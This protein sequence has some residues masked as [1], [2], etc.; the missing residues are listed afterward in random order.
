MR[1]CVCVEWFQRPNDVRLI[2]KKRENKKS[3]REKKMMSTEEITI[4]TMIAMHVQFQT[5]ISFTSF[6]WFSKKFH[7]RAFSSLSLVRPETPSP[8]RIPYPLRSV[9]IL[10]ISPN[11][12]SQI[13]FNVIMFVNAYVIRMSWHGSQRVFI[14]K[15]RCCFYHFT[16]VSIQQH[17]QEPEKAS[18]PNV[19]V[20]FSNGV[21]PSLSFICNTNL[22]RCA[23]VAAW[24]YV[25]LFH[26]FSN[27]YDDDDDGHT[28]HF[29]AAN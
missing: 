15:A 27:D 13:L 7:S 19:S 26:L 18:W 9:I 14:S 4:Q 8:P 1:V 25:M 16:F 29:F 20:F 12:P 24:F 22:A 11:N 5:V 23:T 10:F 17:S 2:T 21:V 3:K 6:I 28:L